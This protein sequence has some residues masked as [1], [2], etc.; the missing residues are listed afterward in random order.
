MAALVATNANDELSS[1]LQEMREAFK[2][3]ELANGTDELF[4]RGGELDDD[5]LERYL[6]ARKMV[7]AD[8][9]EML[10][11]TL[12]W[13]ADFGVRNM[14]TKGYMKVI[15]TETFSGKTYVHGFNRDGHVLLYMRPRRENSNEYDGNLKHVVYNLERCVASMKKADKA[16]SEGKLILLIDF[17]GYSTFNAPP[18]KTSRETLSIIQNHFPERLKKAFIIRAPWI[19][20]AF[21]SMISPFIDPITSKKIQFVKG[22]PEDI[23]K[24]L[25]DPEAGN[26]DPE[27]LECDL[28]GKNRYKFD[29]QVSI[30]LKREAPAKIPPG[31]KLP[32]EVEQGKKDLP[33]FPGSLIDPAMKDSEFLESCKEAFEGTYQECIQRC[34]SGGKGQDEV[35]QTT[36]ESEGGKEGA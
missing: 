19:F 17:A 32:F 23:A 9:R 11:D 16:S 28:G 31:A 12:K 36:E 10:E 27:V 1:K 6:R 15:E 4:G 18:M 29:G 35:A 3:S 25:T 13:R 34:V 20:S 14:H 22:N 30:G 7:V 21:W 33:Q 8:A 5:I 24:I 26:I 2:D